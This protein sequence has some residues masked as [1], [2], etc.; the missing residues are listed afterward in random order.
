MKLQIDTENKIINVIGTVIISDIIYFMENHGLEQ[1]E[2]KIGEVISLPQVN[3]PYIYNT[4]TI[5]QP[6]VVTCGTS[7]TIADNVSATNTKI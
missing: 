3:L 2:Y 7:G 1:Y 5:P 4:E 6:Y